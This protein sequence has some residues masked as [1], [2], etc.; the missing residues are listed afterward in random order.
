MWPKC[1][2]F[3]ES[4]NVNPLKHMLHHSITSRSKIH[5]V[6]LP[7]AP[8]QRRRDTKHELNFRIILC[9]K[10]YLNSLWPQN[11]SGSQLVSPLTKKIRRKWSSNLDSNVTMMVIWT[12]DTRHTKKQSKLINGLRSQGPVHT[13]TTL[14]MHVTGRASVALTHCRG[15]ISGPPHRCWPYF[16]RAL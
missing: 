2:F 11:H 12:N 1:R 5:E 6:N 7:Q 10:I 4:K 8:R 16:M 14:S 15:V 3:Q 9:K 13:S